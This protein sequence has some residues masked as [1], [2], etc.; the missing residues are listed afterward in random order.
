MICISVKDT[1][2][3]SDRGGGA[4]IRRRARCRR[5]AV[6]WADGKKA[7]GLKTRAIGSTLTEPKEYD[8]GLW[9]TLKFAAQAKP[10]LMLAMD[11]SLRGLFRSGF[12]STLLAEGLH[13]PML[14][15]PANLD[16]LRDALGPEVDREGLRRWLDVGVRLGELR[17]G[18][19]ETYSL[20]G[21][22]ARN[23]ASPAA[24][25]HAAY[26][27]ARVEVFHDYVVGTPARLRGGERFPLDPAHGELFAR[28]SR[29]VEPLLNRIV[30]RE[31]P[32]VGAVRLLEV[33]CGSGVYVRRAC[34][35]NPE[36]RAVGLELTEE[37]ASHA[38]ANLSAWG[39]AD[40]ARIETCDVRRYRSDEPFD[41]VTF[42]NLIYYFPVAERTPVLRHL[43]SLLAPGGSL[44]LTTFCRGTDLANATFDLWATMTEGGGALPT[45]TELLKAVEEAGF[46]HVRH[47]S[48]LPGYFLVTAHKAE[49]APAS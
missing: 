42:F 19:G 46:V 18:E 26:F 29:T 7:P 14:Q 17:R 30:E 40:R 49:V 41:V 11:R 47:A 21:S 8:V 4:Q 25:A 45:R 32:L 33:G 38:R 27:R 43:A 34:E 6:R 2:H 24:D 1:C 16:R 35:L 12:V 36:L 22:L 28:S 37:V 20:A 10:L 31:F 23:L 13:E 15:G 5:I 3:V 48:L 44:V 9:T 39:F